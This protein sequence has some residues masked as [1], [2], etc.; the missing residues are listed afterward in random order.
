MRDGRVEQN[1]TPE[2]LYNHPAT[3]FTARFIGTPPMNIMTQ[4]STLLGVRPEHM[5]LVSQGGRPAIVKNVEHLGAD[6]IVV[7]EIDGQAVAIRQDGFIK[8]SPGER[9]QV[10]WDAA[11]EHQFDTASGRRIEKRGGHV[12]MATASTA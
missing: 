1:G 5:R 6:S 7:C 12:Q 4:A 2:E 11:Q 8:T 10:A 3:E 9:I